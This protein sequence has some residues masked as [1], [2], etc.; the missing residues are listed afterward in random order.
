[1][2]FKKKDSINNS[3]IKKDAIEYC[4][5]SL[6]LEKEREQNIVNNCNT[7]ITSNS[8]VLVPLV[9]VLIEALNK[10]PQ[11]NTLLIIFGL[12]LIGVILVGIFLS[13]L[14]QQLYKSVYT[15]SGK[16]LIDFINENDSYEDADFFLDQTLN[17][18]NA[19]YE[20]KCKNND[21]RK[22][23]LFASYICNYAFYCLLSAFI[24][25]IMIVM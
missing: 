16:E 23:L 12:I 11:V 5:R 3:S 15:R 7:M 21:V 8:I 18:L 24:L 4:L 22:N 14:A 25:V 2:L 17:D 10:L 1:M 6:E 13:V 19:I 9:T 20:K